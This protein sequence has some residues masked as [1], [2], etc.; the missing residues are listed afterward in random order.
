MKVFGGIG[1]VLA[2]GIPIFGMGQ[3]V[4]DLKHDMD[5]SKVEVALLKGQVT[6]LQ[7]ILQ[8]TQAAASGSRGTQGSKGDK[9]DPGDVGPLG[10]RGELGPQGPQGVPG[11]EGRGADTARIDAM[12]RRLNEFATVLSQRT[13]SAPTAASPVISKPEQTDAAPTQQVSLVGI[14]R[15]SVSCTNL[16]FSA[17]LTIEQQTGTSGR[18]V[19]EYS[20]SNS[21]KT[22]ATL[23]LSPTKEDP[24][25]YILVTDGSSFDYY[26]NI[27]GDRLAG[28]ITTGSYKC[29]I[30]L[31][32]G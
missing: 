6:Q 24:N 29:D 28:K 16:N 18:G 15:G 26:V 5:S 27:A 17:T 9:G 7:D 23:G 10:P 13:N 32:K 25:R 4:S 3:Y 22:N 31:D 2:V 12:D 1:A 30:N 21:G 8:K 14:W 20:G 19:W 11:V